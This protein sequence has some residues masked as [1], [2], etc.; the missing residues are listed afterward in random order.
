MAHFKYAWYCV[1]RFL[2]VWILEI[3]CLCVLLGLTTKPRISGKKGCFPTRQHEIPQ[4]IYWGPQ[5]KIWQLAKS[6]SLPEGGRS[7]WVQP[8][9]QNPSLLKRQVS[10]SRG[11]S[12]GSSGICC[13]RRI[14]ILLWVFTHIIVYLI[15]TNAPMQ[16]QSECSYSVSV[17]RCIAPTFNGQRSHATQCSHWQ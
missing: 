16:N 8:H 10:S 2:Q 9:W 7:A 6:K 14:Y 3:C 4:N 1:T 11:N 5:G 12:L 13:L 17:H 15:G